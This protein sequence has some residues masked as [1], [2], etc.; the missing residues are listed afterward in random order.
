MGREKPTMDVELKYGCNPHQKPAYLILPDPSPLQVLNGTPGYINLL[1]AFGAWQLVKELRAATGLPSAASFKHTSPAGAAVARPLTE[2]FRRSQML[3]REDL[4]PLACAYARARGGD[5]MSSFGDVAAV[6]DTVDVSLANLLRREVSDLIIAPDFEPA[7]LDLLKT[8]K[9]GEYLILQIDPTYEPPAMETREIFGFKLRQKR[10]DVQIS[11]AHFAQVMTAKQSL[12]DDILETLMV[13]TIALKYTQSNSVC[14]AYDGQVIGMGAGQQSRIH[15]TRLA[16][17]KADKWF[18]QQHPAV[19]ALRFKPSL[20]KTAKTNI[21]DQYLLWDQL[22]EPEIEAMLAGLD[23]RPEP[24][25]RDERLRYIRQFAGICLSSDAFIPFRDNIDRAS[26]S[27]VQFVAQT[28][29]SLRDEEV[30][31]AAAEYGMTMLHTGLRCFL[32]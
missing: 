15:C 1:D 29:N 11:K 20:T 24:I 21:V 10:N 18:L 27:N 8:K 17:D 4:S 13:A 5:R 12:A 26:R 30:T 16:C 9:R 25:E 2:A 28:G 31:Q 32:H 14:V 19:L 22:S 3:P 23:K 6:S 7:A